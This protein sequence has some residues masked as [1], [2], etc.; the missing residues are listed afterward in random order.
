MR[1]GPTQGHSSRVIAPVLRKKLLNRAQWRCEVP[2]C[3]SLLW[4]D[5]LHLRARANG[6]NNEPQNLVV[7]CSGHHRAVHAGGLALEQGGDDRLVVTHSGE[8]TQRG[9]PR[10][11]VG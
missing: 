2:G 1:P 4:L 6:G 8:D 3:S 5:V 7:L 11:D 10:V 9:P